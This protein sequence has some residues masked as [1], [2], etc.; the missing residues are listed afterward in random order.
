MDI[1]QKIQKVS[2]VSSDLDYLRNE[3]NE[4]KISA[5]SHDYTV[6]FESLVKWVIENKHFIDHL[7]STAEQLDKIK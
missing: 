7:A 5:S 3:Y 6:D 4:I 2:S 1:K